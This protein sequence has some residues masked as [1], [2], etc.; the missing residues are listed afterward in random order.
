MAAYDGIATVEIEA[1]RHGMF[2]VANQNRIPSGGL[3][4]LKNAT[5]GDFTWRAGGG[6]AKLGVTAGATISARAGID[7]WPTAALQRNIIAGNDGSVRKDDGLGASWTVLVTTMTTAGAVPHLSVAGAEAAGNA[8]KVFYMDGVNLPRALAADGTVMTTLIS[9]NVDWAGANQPR[10]SCPHQGSN[11]AGGNANA[12]HTAYKSLATDHADFQTTPYRLICGPLPNQQYTVGA[13]SYKGGLLVFC[14]PV[15]VY[16]INTSTDPSSA[17]WFPVQVA[18]PGAGGPRCFCQVEDDVIWVDPAGQW[19]SLAVASAGQDKASIRASD[20]SYRK[21]GSWGSTNMALAQLP[22][23]DL[24]YYSDRQEV[25]LSY[26]PIGQTAKT[27]RLHLDMNNRAEVGENWITWDRDRNE[28]LY[29]R[30]KTGGRE[31]PAMMDNVGQVWELD[32][33]ARTKDGGPYTW[34]FKLQDT[35]FAQ[36]NPKWAGRWKNLRFVQVEAQ[37]TGPGASLALQVWLDGVH[38]QT[39][40]IPIPATGST[41]PQVLPFTLGAAGF[42]MSRPRRLYGRCRRLS[43]RGEIVAAGTDV[44]I[45]KLVVGLEAA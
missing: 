45:S 28:A 3:V 23:A 8:R 32:Q 36:S 34:E 22:Y 11:W 15:G 24:I 20:I 19:H 16:F 4:V 42:V 25:M 33:A 2:A 7:Y 44:H 1:G 37:A 26:A 17:N 30:V 12:P 14:Y 31:I 29:L 9:T 6:A 27:A 40:T 43:L 5:L 41:L 13:L 10:W 18:I 39:I 38:R 35:D 21:L